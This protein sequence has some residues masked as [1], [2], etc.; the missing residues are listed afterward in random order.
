MAL[1]NVE[2]RRILRLLAPAGE[3]LDRKTLAAVAATF[4]TLAD[5]LPPRSATHPRRGDEFLDADLRAG[6][7][8]AIEHGFVLET[9]DGR[10]AMRHELIALAIEDDLLPVQRR[11]H[12]LALAAALSKDPSAALVHWLA[13]YE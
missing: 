8:E 11:R 12:Q 1:R 4:E 6:V 3:P 2:C 7:E 9:A 13:A 10:L 5:G